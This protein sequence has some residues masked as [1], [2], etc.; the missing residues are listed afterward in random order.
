MS[1][2]WKLSLISLARYA[3]TNSSLK[4]GFVRIRFHINHRSSETYA[5][6]IHRQGTANY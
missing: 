5:N 1:V 3:E 4:Y 6:F 2:D